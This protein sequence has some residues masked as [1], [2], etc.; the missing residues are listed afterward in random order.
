MTEFGN[1][2]WVLRR[3][4]E[5]AVRDEDFELV[6]NAVPVPGPGEAL[7]RVHWLGIDPTQRGWLNAGANYLDPVPL[8]TVMRGSG[9]GE[10][11]AS[12]NPEYPVGAWVAGMVGWQD[13]AVASGQGL[14]GL[15]IV[16]PG[17]DPKLMLS[18]FGVTGLTAYFGMVD[19]GRVAEGE[20]VVVTAA[21]GA[22]GSVAA[23]LAKALGCKVIGIAGGPRKC[24]WLTETAGLDAAIDY[25]HE[26]V[27]RQLA[28][29]A[30]EG[31]DVFFDSVGGALLDQGLERLAL[32]ARVVLCGGI[33]SGYGAEAPAT[34][35]RNYMALAMK[36]ARMEG[37][38]VLDYLERFPEAFAALHGW[39]SAGRIVLAETVVDGLESAPSALRGL[40]EGA[41]LGKQLV[42][43]R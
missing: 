1:R 19:I 12:D 5:G 9:V 41:N 25:K 38:I 3:R 10:I 33:A 2:Q 42:R 34:G 8:D 29:L 35:L 11:V 31:I 26:Q 17:V 22:T 18:L 7:V 27:G 6:R 40:F 30:P 43:V 14:F 37:F 24:A 39:H 36:R 28:D 13:Y 15:N 23:Q 20:T 32:R 21:A 16:P 4:P